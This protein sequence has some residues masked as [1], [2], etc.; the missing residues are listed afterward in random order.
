MTIGEAIEKYKEKSE[1][2]KGTTNVAYGL[3]LEQI[4]EWLEELKEFKENEHNCKDCAGCT[5]WKCNCSNERARAID[6]FA[7]RL[8]EL[9]GYE[10]DDIQYPYLLHES[11]IDEI[12][13]QMK[14]GAE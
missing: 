12:A 14:V 9:C 8:H 5:N 3:E 11:R 13:E 10:E 1:F 7:E 4:V 6:D 2:Y